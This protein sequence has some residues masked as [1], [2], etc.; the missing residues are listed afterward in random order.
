MTNNRSVEILLT[1]SFLAI[2]YT[3]PTSQFV[4]ELVNEKTPEVF[5]IVTQVPTEQYLR[6]FESNLEN[7]SWVADTVR[8]LLQQLHFTVLRD[9]ADNIVLGRDDWLFYK[10]GVDYLLPS[11]KEPLVA[12]NGPAEAITAI[13]DFRDQL[14]KHGIQL[15]VV[16]VPGKASVYPD[17]LTQRALDSD[18]SLRSPTLKVIEKLRE[19]QVETID[20]F[21]VFQTARETETPHADNRIYLA[22]DTHWSPHGVQLAAKTISNHINRLHWIQTGDV[23]YHRNTVEILRTGDIVQMMPLSVLQPHYPAEQLQ[24]KQV[25]QTT[26]SLLYQDDPNAAVLLLGDSFS[27]IY[28]TDKPRSAGLISQL[29]YEL[30][31]P[32]SSI[33]NDGGSSTLVRQQLARQPELLKDK[34]LIIWQFIE[35]DIH[36]GT[37]GWQVIPV[38]LAN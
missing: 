23:E 36:F 26:K 22:Q 3:V 4:H 28:Q 31:I 25:L 37:E 30:K 2:L 15:L 13:V 20:L 5:Q 14:L 9:P 6:D 18:W 19:N 12:H 38:S 24:C 35:R 32:L 21:A 16:P 8:P 10:P 1:V 27:R 29:A 17:R 7:N 33:V 34:K 11:R